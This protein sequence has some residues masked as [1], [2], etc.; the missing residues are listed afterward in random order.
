M[1][2]PVKVLKGFQRVALKPG[3]KKKVT[4]ITPIEQLKWFNEK[5]D[6]WEMESM[7]YD[8]YLGT[9]SSEKDL[10]LEKLSL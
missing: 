7:E 8:L 3:E 1:D 9:S 6:T 5:T 10:I 4:I 2:R